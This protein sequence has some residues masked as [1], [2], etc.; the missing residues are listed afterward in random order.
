MLFWPLLKEHDRSSKQVLNDQLG[1]DRCDCCLMLEDAKIISRRFFCQLTHFLR[2]KSVSLFV[3]IHQHITEYL[4][5][6]SAIL[7]E[8]FFGS[9]SRE[10]DLF[11]RTSVYE[12]FSNGETKWMQ[13]FKDVHGLWR[14]LFSFPRSHRWDD[15]ERQWRHN[16]SEI[17]EG[18]SLLIIDEQ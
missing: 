16:G 15:N 17:M 14:F 1:I 12:T 3:I 10:R 11:R 8:V 5:N 13:I 18:S 9:L 7:D 4:A 6:C 2:R